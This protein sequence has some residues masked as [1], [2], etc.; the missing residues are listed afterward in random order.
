MSYLFQYQF[1]QCLECFINV[2]VCLG[3]GLQEGDALIVGQGSPPVPWHNS[4][5]VPVTLVADQYSLYISRC[6]LEGEWYVC[7]CV[8]E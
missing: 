8:S 2:A 3:R 6:M 4:T 1:S 7:V 5:S